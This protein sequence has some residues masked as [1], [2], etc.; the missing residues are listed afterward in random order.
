MADTVKHTPVQVLR[1]VVQYDDFL[2][3]FTGPIESI[4]ATQK[5]EI[6]AA[7]DQMVEAARSAL[8]NP[9]E[10]TEGQVEAAIEAYREG[11]YL[12]DE[13]VFASVSAI[14]RAAFAKAEGRS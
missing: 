6:D 1:L 2:R 7:Y 12:T 4:T 5:A 13:Q 3:T 10:P 11:E 9:S 8:D 14:V